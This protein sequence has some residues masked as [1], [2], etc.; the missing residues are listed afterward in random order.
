MTDDLNNLR[1]NRA[2]ARIYE[3]ANAIG[4]ALQVQ[5]KPES[6]TAALHEAGSFLVTLMAPMMPHLAEESW[7]VLGNHEAIVYSKWPTILPE[8]IAVDEVTIAVQINGKRRDEIT[9]AM[10]LERAAVE[11]AALALESVKRQLE[12]K[13]IKKVIVVPG[14]IVNIVCED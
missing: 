2:I 10:G 3:L 7:K 12:G 4:Q 9:V 14:R 11:A 8:L 1:F 13:T 6:L 5:N